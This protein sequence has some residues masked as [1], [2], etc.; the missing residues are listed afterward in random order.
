MKI[1]PPLLLWL[2][3]WLS[4]GP[5]PAAAHKA[6]D[7]Y[8]VLS[9]VG[10]QVDARVDV[11]L[12]DLDRDLALDADDDGRLTWGELRT[13]SAEIGALV[14]RALQLRADGSECRAADTA[15]LQL[16]EHSD[17][18]YAVLTRRYTC[19]GA[20]R[21][22]QV[23]YGLFAHSDPTHRGILRVDGGQ[24]QQAVLVPGDA[25]L[26]LRLQ[27]DG[28][29]STSFAGFVGEGLHH[30]LVGADHVLF[31]LT[32]L[33][34]AVWRRDDGR[35]VPVERAAP[36]WAETARL[37][38]AFTLG[39]SVTLA[40]AALGVLAPP[41]RWVESL[42]AMSVF[43]AAVDNLRPFVPAPRWMVVAA[44]G[45]VHGF[46]FAGPLQALG[47]SPGR[48]WQPLL[49]FNLGVELG[50]LAIVAAVLP[51]ALALRH[52]PLY[53]RWVV[54][55][56]SGAVAAL[57]LAWTLERSLELQLLP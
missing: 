31:L 23:S 48:L 9:V 29:P 44:F 5:S 22:L 43:V 20:V 35:W 57:A 50:Q 27:G 3:L 33:V 38:T 8:L 14:D 2:A 53:G 54:R 36:A 15:P 56:G 1:A 7:A 26:E 21:S 52:A 10:A 19:A 51:V 40:L 30:I 25:P 17:G 32:L 42:I 46:G 49:G 34:V 39:H 37:V 12:R 6:S 28:T 13:R 4:L 45:L 18:R 47:L 16:D 55:G 41:S 24:P 11:A